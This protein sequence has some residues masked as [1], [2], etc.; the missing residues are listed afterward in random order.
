MSKQTGGK[1]KNKN[2]F[3]VFKKH[4]KTKTL[5]Q[6]RYFEADATVIFQ[7]IEKAID[8]H[9]Q[10]SKSCPLSDTVESASDDIADYVK[11]SE[12]TTQVKS[13]PL[14]LG[15]VEFSHIDGEFIRKH[16]IVATFFASS[17]THYNQL[18]PIIDAEFWDFKPT[19]SNDSEVQSAYNAKFSK[20]KRQ[21]N[22]FKKEFHQDMKSKIGLGMSFA[23]FNYNPSKSSHYGMPVLNAFIYDSF[24][25]LVC[26][27]DILLGKGN[28][29]LISKYND[30]IDS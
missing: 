22:I 21:I 11:S 29:G 3:K 28:E 17:S 25:Q 20:E 26:Y 10:L 19:I 6:E 5:N 14:G 8:V 15:L 2:K 13:G 24:S 16:G 23:H 30:L 12:F 1:R 18:Q 9:N 4:K 27:M 7:N